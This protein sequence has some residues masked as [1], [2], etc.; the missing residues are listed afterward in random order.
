MVNP[1]DLRAAL[2]ANPKGKA[3][4]RQQRIGQT[5]LVRYRRLLHLGSTRSR[6]LPIVRGDP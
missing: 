5:M 3:T 4:A 1:F 2:L 6:R